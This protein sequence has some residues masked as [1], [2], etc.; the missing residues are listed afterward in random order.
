M[1]DMYH[2][3]VV[4]G[5]RVLTN[6][7]AFLLSAEEARRYPAAWRGVAKETKAT[8]PWLAA[9]KT[10]PMGDGIAVVVDMPRK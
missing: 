1:R 5:S 7:V 8:G 2:G 6:A 10:F 9:F 4:S 3:F